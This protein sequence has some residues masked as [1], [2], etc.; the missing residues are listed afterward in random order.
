[1]Y[2]IIIGEYLRGWRCRHAT[3]GAAYRDYFAVVPRCPDHRPV[4]TKLACHIKT[5]ST[6]DYLKII[7]KESK[8][9]VHGM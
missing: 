8:I 4:I 5:R 6:N 9:Q 1:M 3:Q 2:L 7:H